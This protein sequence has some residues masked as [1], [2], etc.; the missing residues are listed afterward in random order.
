[1][2]ALLRNPP[3][4]LKLLVLQLMVVGIGAGAARAMPGSVEPAFHS[5]VLGACTTT[6]A[7]VPAV[8]AML[9]DRV[10]RAYLQL[11]TPRSV[12]GA[13]IAL[14][15]ASG[16]VCLAAAAFATASASVPSWV[17]D[18][19][20]V[21]GLSLLA[22]SFLS[23]LLLFRSLRVGH[24]TRRLTIGEADE[25][26]SCVAASFE[27]GI[28][29][30]VSQWIE[31]LAALPRN[32]DERAR[33]AGD[34]SA[35][36]R[37]FVMVRYLQTDCW[38]AIVEMAR[39]AQDNASQRELCLR[40]IEIA[41][42]E[43]LS[44][45]L[46]SEILSELAAARVTGTLPWAEALGDRRSERSEEVRSLVIDGGGSEVLLKRLDRLVRS[47]ASGPDS[48]A[49]EALFV[50]LARRTSNASF[51]NDV[52]DV[53]WRATSM[54]PFRRWVD[55][56]GD[57]QAADVILDLVPSRAL[58][59]GAPGAG[60]TS[61]AEELAYLLQVIETRMRH[62]GVGHGPSGRA[63]DLCFVIATNSR[64]R[65][66]SEG[67]SALCGIAL[68]ACTAESTLDRFGVPHRVTLGKCLQLWE[69]ANRPML[70]QAEWYQRITEPLLAG[71]NAAGL[72]PHLEHLVGVAPEAP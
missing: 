24:L 37:R 71:E 70:R 63:V 47:E 12:A 48:T 29:R 62:D 69:R 27:Q 67:I 16:L 3:G 49:V 6:L 42:V 44:K 61:A 36:S 57:G 56:V 55:R 41:T 21:A 7:L 2:S 8:I 40:A 45:T 20:V 4:F 30:D 15:L 60:G 10:P 5:A 23:P 26:R 58:K 64:I 33:I 28:H 54:P 72:R 53:R 35:L 39:L 38:R 22:G 25:V 18:A 46:L 13:S 65:L 59:G 9:I 11:W 68:Q 34:I 52:S 50:D 19:E 31:A 51:R 1:M 17:V 14:A 66:S 32:D 43:R